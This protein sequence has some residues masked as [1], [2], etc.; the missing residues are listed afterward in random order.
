M[1]KLSQIAS[2]NPALTNPYRTRW[3]TAGGRYFEVEAKELR[4]VWYI[5]EVD[6]D[7]Q[8]LGP[9]AFG[10]I[11]FT[12]AEARTLIDNETTE[13]TTRKEPTMAQLDKVYAH[14]LQWAE[15]FAPTPERKVWNAH[16]PL[17]GSTAWEGRSRWGTHYSVGR[18]DDPQFATWERLNAGLD[19]REV[20]LLDNM[21]AITLAGELA[22]KANRGDYGV[23]A[24]VAAYPGHEGAQMFVETYD[25]PWHSADVTADAFLAALVTA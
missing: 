17:Y 18:M 4:G 11:A 13:T 3:A 5:H 16:R 25:L 23:G 9:D 7:G 2:W 12:L 8:W 22:R 20:V 10:A 24:Y 19:A 6:T 1:V 15:S 21:E 14:R